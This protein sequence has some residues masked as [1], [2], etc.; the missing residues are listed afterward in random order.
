MKRHAMQP[1]GLS[2]GVLGAL[3]LGLMACSPAATPPPASAPKEAATAPAASLA[4]LV[5]RWGVTIEACAAT[6]DSRDGVIEI[7]VGTVQVG[8]DKCTVTRETPEPSEVMRI[9]VSAT[10]IGGEGGGYER[11]FTFVSSSPSTLTWVKEGGNAEP[12]SR[13]P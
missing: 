13:C 8:L 10:C 11:P 7:G 2:A 9:T 5:G 1:L 4:S 3:A 12:Y 6:N